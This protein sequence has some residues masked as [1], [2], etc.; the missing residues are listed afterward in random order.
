MRDPDALD[1]AR[2]VAVALLAT[3]ALG[4][5][6]GQGWLP[7]AAVAPLIQLVF[8]ASPL[9]YA[10]AAGL[11]ALSGSGFRVPSWKALLFV[12]LASAASLW[13]LKGLHDG[14]LALFRSWGLEETA[15][16]EEL[17]TERA[18]QGVQD[19]IGPWGLALFVIF[20]P[21]CEETLFRGLA[22]RGFVKG[23]G[24]GRALLYTALL[25]AA[26]HGTLVQILLMSFLGFF[27]GAVVLLSGSLWC[28]ILAHALNNLA[29]LAV[30]ERFGPAAASLP[31][32][33]WMF[34]L[35]L[36]VLAGA[37]ACLAYEGRGGAGGAGGAGSR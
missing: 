23:F 35:A 25:F 37:L 20:P 27:F 12:A 31:V 17:R 28:G 32:P 21:L 10:R 7:S 18:V 2:I 30:R 6:A 14:Q 26:L 3:A 16:S 11:P 1:G 33:G 13:I 15:R 19:R 24:A 5:A 34:C 22:L 9:A 8:L 4:L 36:L 29:V